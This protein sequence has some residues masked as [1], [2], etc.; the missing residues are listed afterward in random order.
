MTLSDILPL[1]RF[2]AVTPS[3]DDEL[4]PVPR[5]VLAGTAGV[6]SVVDADGTVTAV[7]VAAGI[8]HPMRPRKIRA[9]GTTA[10]NIVSGR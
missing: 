5:A 4:N 10:T 8:W 1:E 9:T 6:L 3:N 2:A 7:T